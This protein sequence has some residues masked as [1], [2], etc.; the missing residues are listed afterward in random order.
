MSIDGVALTE[1]AFDG[2]FSPS[3]A[4]TLMKSLTLGASIKGLKIYRRD[5]GSAWLASS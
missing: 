4:I 3:G 1:T 5:K 2:S